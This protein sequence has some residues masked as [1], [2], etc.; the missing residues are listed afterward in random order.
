MPPRWVRF[1][2]FDIVFAIGRAGETR[3][4]RPGHAIRATAKVGSWLCPLSFTISSSGDST[5]RA[6]RA[7]ILSQRCAALALGAQRTAFPLGQRGTLP[8]LALRA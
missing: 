7:P 5:T 1:G 3:N 4:P 2:Q 6:M 8:F